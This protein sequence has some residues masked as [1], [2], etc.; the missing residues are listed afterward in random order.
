MQG[1][2]IKSVGH[3]G[4]AVLNIRMDREDPVKR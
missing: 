4:L 2:M 3:R 1:K